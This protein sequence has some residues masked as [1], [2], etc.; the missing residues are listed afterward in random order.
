MIGG[1]R[2][3][4]SVNMTIQFPSNRL[5]TKRC[6]ECGRLK[7]ITEFYPDQR[8]RDGRLNKCMDCV[9]ERVRA[10]REKNVDSIR[11]YDR[12]RA[13]RPERLLDLVETMRRIRREHP[14]K[15]KAH[16]AL[17]NAVRDGRIM[18]QPCEV[19]GRKDAHGHHEDYS[20]PLDVIWLCPVCHSALHHQK[21]CLQPEGDSVRQIQGKEGAA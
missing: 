20:K 4:P 10:H 14:E 11:Q 12:D 1:T 13:K 19:C 15:Y 21:L 7:P 5:P 6:Q 2:D 16:N 3:K 8:M 9:R 17:S 18:R